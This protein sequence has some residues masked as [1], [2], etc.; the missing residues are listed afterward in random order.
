MDIPIDVELGE[1]GL[2]YGTSPAMKGLLVTGKTAEQ[3]ME[4]VP[5]AIAEMREAMCHADTSASGETVSPSALHPGDGKWLPIESAPRD[6]TDV[7][8]YWP[9]FEIDG[10]DTGD[11]VDV[12]CWCSPDVCFT[13]HWS[14]NGRWTPGDDPTHWMPLPP[15]PGQI[16]EPARATRTAQPDG[17]QHDTNKLEEAKEIIRLF[18]GIPIP[19]EIDTGWDCVNVTLLNCNIRRARSFLK[20]NGNG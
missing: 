2:Y 17:S 13:E 9:N 10:R 6:G 11:R 18:S 8:C 5:A 15:A 16:E 7:I 1:N 14:I 19:E 20:E 4:K 3:V 12:A